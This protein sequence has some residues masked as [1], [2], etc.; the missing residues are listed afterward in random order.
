MKK[1]IE[2][3]E[4]L[5]DKKNVL[6][7]MVRTLEKR[8]L[9]DEVKSKTDLDQLEFD[10]KDT[11]NKNDRYSRDNENMKDELQKIKQINQEK[12]NQVRTLMDKLNKINED[13]RQQQIDFNMLQ[14][15][16]IT[17]T[18]KLKLE[19]DR[20]SSNDAIIELKKE[21]KELEKHVKKGND[22]VTKLTTRE[23]EYKNEIDEL[24]KKNKDL[25]NTEGVCK[26]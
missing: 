26:S 17:E 6:E 18:D 14:T 7:N 13:S 2:E 24:T 20:L 23:T 9:T 1:K 5:R 15:K 4:K 25:K 10:L 3:L 16:Y 22:D 11:K 19:N 8:L 21:N 12:E